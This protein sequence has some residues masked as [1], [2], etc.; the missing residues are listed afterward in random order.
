[1]VTPIALTPAHNEPANVF[2]LMSLGAEIGSVGKEKQY[3]LLLKL[4][5]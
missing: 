5:K 4:Q 2:A 1:M 3:R